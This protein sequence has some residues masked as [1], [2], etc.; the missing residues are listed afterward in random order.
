MT[1]I[2][3]TKPQL[4]DNQLLNGSH[5]ESPVKEHFAKATKCQPLVLDLL[6]STEQPLKMREIFALIQEI[7]GEY[8]TSNI[9]HAV[10]GLLDEGKVEFTA[11]FGV[12]LSSGFSAQR[13]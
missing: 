8:T 2:L 3:S 4:E 1:E 12:I 11:D 7:D 10:I 6:S 5:Q 9:Q 13:V